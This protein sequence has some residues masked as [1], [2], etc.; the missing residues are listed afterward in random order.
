MAGFS[1]MSASRLRSQVDRLAVF[2]MPKEFE[3]A[4][5]LGLLYNLDS[6][7]VGHPR[8]SFM[9]AQNQYDPSPPP[10]LQWND[11]MRWPH[12]HG[13]PAVWTVVD[14]STRVYCGPSATS[15]KVSA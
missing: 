5:M 11:V 7:D 13:A 14:G 4:A 8:Q 12:L 9:A 3:V 10:C 6:G 15:S 1:A 2:M